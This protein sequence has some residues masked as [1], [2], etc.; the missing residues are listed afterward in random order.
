MVLV[1]EDVPA[2]LQGKRPR[3]IPLQLFLSLLPL[4][5]LLYRQDSAGEHCWLRY[6]FVGFQLSLHPDNRL[7]PPFSRPRSK[8]QDW[9]V[10]LRHLIPRL[11]S[12][13][14]G[15]GRGFGDRW[16]GLERR[17]RGDGPGWML[18]DFLLGGRGR[19]RHGRDEGLG[20]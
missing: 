7:Q 17:S 4:L 9:V 3:G 2:K 14:R 20:D 16:I 8:P 15:G 18:L 10:P 12:G 6:L 5:S 1:M 13:A 19:W 11:F